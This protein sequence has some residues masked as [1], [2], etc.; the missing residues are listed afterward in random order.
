MQTNRLEAFSDGVLAIAITVM[1]LE[2]KK[3]E[4]ADFEALKSVIPHFISYII[5]FVYVGI[6]WNNHHHLFHAVEK[7]NGSILWANLALLFCLSL[8]PFTTSWMSESYFA[9]PPVF[10]YG[11]NLLCCAV[12]YTVL[13]N[14][15]IK[16]H[17]KNSRISTILKNKTKELAAIAIYLSSII[18]ACYFPIISL[19]GYTIVALIWLIPDKR[20]EKQLKD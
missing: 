10:L 5:S 15:A 1:V 8:L 7:V 6:Y 3:P 11:I 20:I 12:A 16:Y 17:G 13:E 9:S 4:S 2:M 19:I 14:I 18:F